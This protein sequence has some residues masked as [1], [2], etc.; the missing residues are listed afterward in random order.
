MRLSQR[1]LPNILSL[2]R[3]PIAAAFVVVYDGTDTRRFWFGIGLLCIAVLTDMADGRI[4]RAYDLTSRTGYFLDG[5]GDKVVY[6]AVLMVIFREDRQQA[7][8]AWLLV[9]REIILYA[10]R[11]IAAGDEATLRRLRPLSLT[12]AL[13]IRLYFLAFFLQQA[14]SL[15]DSGGTRITNWYVLL[16]YLAALI[17]YF[18]FF[19]IAKQ[20]AKSV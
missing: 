15:Y 2:S 9:A 3:I 10:L 20:M 16:G 17:G 11:A 8:L 1:D 12:Y 18:Y 4:A 6:A 7:L 5:I 14:E 13:L 19:L